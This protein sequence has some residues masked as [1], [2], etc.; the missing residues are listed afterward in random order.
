ME[1]SNNKEALAKKTIETKIIQKI[2]RETERLNVDNISRTKAYQNYYFRNKDFFWPFLAS[3]V[4]R[5]AGWNMTDLQQ[6]EFRVIMPQKDRRWLFYT[7]ERA[8]WLI[9]EDAY[10]QL[11]LYEASKQLRMPLFHLLKE[12]GVSRF[13]VGEWELFWDRHDPNRLD[14]ALIINEQHVIEG[15]V[16]EQNAYKRK[17][18]A[19]FPYWLQDR[20]HFSTVLFPT[21]EGELYG[22]SVHGFRNVS[23]RI[24]HGKRLLKILSDPKMSERFIRFARM[25]EP[26][27]GRY[28]Y[29]R[30]FDQKARQ[31]HHFPLRLLFPIIH[32]HRKESKDWSLK[33]RNPV[34]YFRDVGLP[35]QIQLNDWYEHKRM[36]LHVLSKLKSFFKHS[37]Q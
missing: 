12:F 30:L 23:K 17:V 18:F 20:F 25:T 24:D 31:G 36:E 6:K 35:S 29:E 8:N 15:P 5:N 27:G 37:I 7:Y 11:L 10:P 3:M 16:L 28:D 4:S 34:K 19:T 32:H 9:F 22:I 14:I 2:K 21:L 1:Q 13:M 26:S 33:E